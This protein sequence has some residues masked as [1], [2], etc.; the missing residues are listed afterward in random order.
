MLSNVRTYLLGKN[1][2]SISFCPVGELDVKTKK[3]KKLIIYTQS[4]II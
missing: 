1:K 2:R 3:K 4:L